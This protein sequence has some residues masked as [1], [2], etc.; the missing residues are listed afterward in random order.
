MDVAAGRDVS[1][2]EVDLALLGLRG[3]DQH[4]FGVVGP[5]CPRAGKEVLS[6]LGRGVAPSA[7]EFVLVADCI[8]AIA[9]VRGEDGVWRFALLGHSAYA[10]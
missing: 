7:F 6:L 10:L 8:A 1:H 9:F 2:P 4:D 5:P 3:L